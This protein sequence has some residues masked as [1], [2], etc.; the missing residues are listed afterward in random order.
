MTEL[1]KTQ[2]SLLLG[3]PG[4]GKSTN[5]FLGLWRVTDKGRQVWLL[6]PTH[7]AR[8]SLRAN[9]DKQI[10]Q[11]LLDALKRWRASDTA[12]AW[13]TVTT[14]RTR[15]YVDEASMTCNELLILLNSCIRHS[16]RDDAKIVLVG[17]L[18]QQVPIPVLKMVRLACLRALSVW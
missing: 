8:E 1:N 13:N 10:A 4:T 12:L 16:A 18:K 3:Q 9:I 11:S 2:I 6:T 5:W 15:F 14:C 17:D 7:G